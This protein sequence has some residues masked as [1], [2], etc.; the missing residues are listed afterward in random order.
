MGDDSLTWMP[1]WKLRDLIV[2]KKVSP[3][4]VTKHFLGRIERLDPT[5]HAFITVVPELAL[6]QA[7]AAERKLI[8]GKELGPLVGVPI[9]LKDLL[10]TKGIRTTGGSL[11]YK[12]FVPTE[13]SVW[14]E[15]VKKADAV[16]VG[17]TNTPEFGMGGGGRTINRLVDECVNPWDPNRTCGS[18]SGGAAASVVSGMTP[19]A[20][21]SDG[22][23]SIRIPAAFCGVFGLHP[24]NGRVPR[25]GDMGSSLFFAGVGPITR[26]VRDAAIIFRVLAGPDPRDPTCMKDTPPDYL[27]NLEQGVRGLRLA[28]VPDAGRVEGIQSSVVETVGKA[29]GQFEEL[30]AHVE[31][32]GITFG[33]EEVYEAFRVMNTV[34]RCVLVGTQLYD[35]PAT[36]G[37]LA[38]GMLEAFPFARRV[39]A[40]EY[41]RAL[42]ARFRFIDRLE[43]IF[44]GYDLIL[45]PS[46]SMVAP[47]R[48]EVSS[49]RLSEAYSA[50]TFIVNF[51]GFAAAS[52]PAG[53]VDGMPVGMQV[54]G[55]PNDEATVLRASRALEQAQP[56]AEKHPSMN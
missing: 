16:V 12:D 24:S 43:K 47:P 34:D 8:G 20:L 23:G 18:S 32:P 52:V 38:S 48:E 40:A 13:D 30:G 25:Y 42:Q 17:K 2:Q 33:V 21:G 31:E 26:D 50:Y 54:I 53:F 5:L 36:R 19:V 6:E 3:V 51:S 27:G 29:V 15:R 4:E 41:S 22:G 7:R 46:G 28:W 9:S 11:V 56:W 49:T 45:S 55:R 14:A 37:L 10:W 39:T 44:Q 35:D 1:G